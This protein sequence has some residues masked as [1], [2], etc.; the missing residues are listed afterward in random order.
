MPIFL[1]SSSWSSSSGWQISAAAA[2]SSSPFIAT[3]L[4][5][6]SRF[7][8]PPLAA[9]A[10]STAAKDVAPEDRASVD[11]VSTNAMSRES[12]SVTVASS[13]DVGVM[14]RADCWWSAVLI[15]GS[16]VV[17]GSSVN[18]LQALGGGTSLNDVDQNGSVTNC[19]SN[20]AG[21]VKPSSRRW[22]WLSSDNI[23]V[24]CWNT[25]ACTDGQTDSRTARTLAR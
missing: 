24:V 15:E 10:V 6:F 2:E 20:A 18:V 9:L 11:S 4:S 19:S 8:R 22:R 3:L 12:T 17:P 21:G 14:S 1:T 16:V 5:S 13:G 23:G 7:D 25:R